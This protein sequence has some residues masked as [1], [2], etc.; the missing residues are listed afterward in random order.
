MS[1]AL[2][3]LNNDIIRQKQCADCG[4]TFTRDTRNTY[5]YWQRAKFCSRQ[6]S[7][8][9]WAKLS[10]ARRLSIRDDFARW[11]EKQ[12]DGCWNWTGALDRDG[13]GIF[14]HEAKTRRAHRG[15]ME[16]DGRP[17]TIGV[18]ACHTC[19]NRRCVNPEHLFSGTPSEN[20]ADAVAK[21]RTAK[22]EA[23]GNAKLTAE[24][25]RAIRASNDPAPALAKRF[26][27][28]RAAIHFVINGATWKHVD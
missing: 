14:C 1:R 23:A 19:D 26:N 5:A 12:E 20:V 13:Y 8:N 2:L 3:I 25:V 15:S 16:L 22:G 4:A 17:L 27:V 28:S 10:A 9:S 18:F 6:C 11:F 21:S 7:A 24:I